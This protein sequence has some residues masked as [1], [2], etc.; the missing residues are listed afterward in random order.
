MT[1]KELEGMKIGGYRDGAEGV[2]ALPANIKTFDCL[3]P[4]VGH[5]K[6]AIFWQGVEMARRVP[7]GEG[8]KLCEQKFWRIKKYVLCIQVGHFT[9]LFIEN[10]KNNYADSKGG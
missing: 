5:P 6:N 4:R 10:E 9:S 3:S 8:A 2:K 7:G 1:E